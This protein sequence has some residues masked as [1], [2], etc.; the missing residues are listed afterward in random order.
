[1]NSM[2]WIFVFNTYI[3]N[4]LQYINRFPLAEWEDIYE[5]DVKDRAGKGI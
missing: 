1:M 3:A 5:A 2:C 4:V